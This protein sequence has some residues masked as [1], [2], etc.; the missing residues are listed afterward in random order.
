VILTTAENTVIDTGLA[1]IK[2]TIIAGTAVVVN[3][4]DRLGAVIAINGEN[5]D[6]SRS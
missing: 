2:V 6:C 1:E 5:A 3:I 4:G